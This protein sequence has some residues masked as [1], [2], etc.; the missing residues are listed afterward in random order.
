MIYLTNREHRR[1]WNLKVLL[2]D[3]EIN[4]M[5]GEFTKAREQEDIDEKK[6]GRFIFNRSYGISI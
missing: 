1:E 5:E 3:I 4:M 2:N 6:L